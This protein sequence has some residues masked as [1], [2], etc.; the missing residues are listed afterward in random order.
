MIGRPRGRDGELVAAKVP[1]VDHYSGST[2]NQQFAEAL[3]LC[4]Q[5]E[6][7]IDKIIRGRIMILSGMILPDLSPSDRAASNGS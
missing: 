1:G 3:Q 4:V 2:R 5:Y 7:E 6:Q